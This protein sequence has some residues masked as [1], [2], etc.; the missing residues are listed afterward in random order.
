MEE[1]NAW[2]C[3]ERGQEM[4]VNEM[5]HFYTDTNMSMQHN[6]FILQ[7]IISVEGCYGWMIEAYHHL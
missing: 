3:G 4:D 1:I 6:W 7:C 2:S 5:N